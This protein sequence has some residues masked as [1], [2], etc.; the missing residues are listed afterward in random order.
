MPLVETSLILRICIRTWIPEVR[1]RDH[2]LA[3]QEAAPM[4]FRDALAKRL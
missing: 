4:D 2:L 3:A 1:A